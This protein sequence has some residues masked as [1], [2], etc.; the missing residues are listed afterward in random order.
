LEA[1]RLFSAHRWELE[2][3]DYQGVLSWIKLA[4]KVNKA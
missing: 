4:N 2:P 3:R 1:L